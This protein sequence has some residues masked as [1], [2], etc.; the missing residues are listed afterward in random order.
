MLYHKNMVEELGSGGGSEENI[1]YGVDFFE[2]TPFTLNFV[3]SAVSI[4]TYVS[5]SR[6]WSGYQ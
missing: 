5:S 1:M 6:S 3:P 2:M 4:T